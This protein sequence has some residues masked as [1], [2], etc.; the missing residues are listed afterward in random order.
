[1]HLGDRQCEPCTASTARLSGDGLNAFAAQEPEWTVV[2][3]HH[4]RRLFR[5]PDFQSALRFVN[6]VGAVAEEQGHHPNIDFTWGRVALTI[7]THT[8][9][10]LS[11]NDFILAARISKLND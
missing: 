8:I 6:R 3:G 1:M 2:D 9:D 11:E 10:G 5:F 7:F 4:L